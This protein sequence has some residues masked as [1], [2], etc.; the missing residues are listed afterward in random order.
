MYMRMFLEGETSDISIHISER[1]APIFSQIKT[2]YKLK[3][4]HLEAQIG[5]Q[6]SGPDR[7]VFTLKFLALKI[8][9]FSPIKNTF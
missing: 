7:H 3:S 9:G 1:F 4:R 5:E 2:S 6:I 8:T